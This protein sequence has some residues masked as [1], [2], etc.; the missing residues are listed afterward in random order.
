VE[1]DAVITGIKYGRSGDRYFPA[2]AFVSYVV[3][4]KK[5][6][7]K[8][9]RSSDEQVGQHVKIFYNPNN[10]QDVCGTSHSSVIGEITVG[11]VMTLLGV[12]TGI[13]LITRGAKRKKG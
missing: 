1:G 6:D 5:Y 12:G 10:P 13:F 11:G 9:A 8:I 4:E 7:G 2:P 3:D